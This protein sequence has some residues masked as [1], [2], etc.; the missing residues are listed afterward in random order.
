MVCVSSHHG[1]IH[2]CRVLGRS[3]NVDDSRCY[4]RTH[5]RTEGG[6]LRQLPST[7]KGWKSKLIP[8]AWHV[9]VEEVTSYTK[10]EGK[11]TKG[12]RRRRRR[13]QRRHTGRGE[14]RRSISTHDAFDAGASYT[15]TGHANS[16][17][18]RTHGERATTS[19]KLC[20]S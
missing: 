17:M 8:T 2:S 4:V 9:G 16:T 14:Q 10:S 7:G 19:R 5:A 3:R 12:R 18:N 20:F 6:R 15:C 13:R 11:T 1:I